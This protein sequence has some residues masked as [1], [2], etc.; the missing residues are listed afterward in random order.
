[1]DQLHK[2]A[3]FLYEFEKINGADFDRLMKG[4]FAV[5]EEHRS[6][7]EKDSKKPAIEQNSAEPQK[8]SQRFLIRLSISHPDR[9]SMKK[10]LLRQTKKNNTKNQHIP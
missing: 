3:D 6:K 2:V 9:T 5:F 10:R 4:D 7:K 8:S 1:M